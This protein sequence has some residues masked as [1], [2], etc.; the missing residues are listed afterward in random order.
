MSCENL[1]VSTNNE[2]EDLDFKKL[3]RVSS[4]LLLARYNN[5]PAIFEQGDDRFLEKQV[6]DAMGKAAIK[7]PFEGT[8]KLISGH[9]FPDIVANKLYGVEVKSIKHNRWTTIG[10]SVLES[11][12]VKDVERIYIMCGKLTKPCKFRWRKYEECLDAIVVTHSP[13]YKININLR[14]KQTIFDEMKISYDDFRTL[15]NPI[16]HFVEYYRENHPDSEVLWWTGPRGEE[17]TVD[18]EM[19][20]WSKLSTGEKNWLIALS[21]IKFPE[22]FGPAQRDKYEKVAAF[23]VREKGVV[24]ASLRDNFS[25]GGRVMLSLNGVAYYKIPQIFQRLIDHLPSIFQGLKELKDGP[26]FSEWLKSIE[27]YIDSHLKTSN[28][29]TQLGALTSASLF[30]FIKNEYRKNE[31]R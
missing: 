5:S 29:P 22:I 2:P 9:K 21:M 6:C 7:T 20:Q 11:S 27:P 14:N 17:K 26:S 13:R 10:N 30:Q 24:C 28:N 4:S 31:K 25:A 1:I 15:E 23:L 8:I 19:R 12:R 18:F 3:L 16:V